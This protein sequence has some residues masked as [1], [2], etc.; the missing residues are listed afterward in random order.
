MRRYRIAEELGGE[1]AL[2]DL[3]ARALRFGIRLAADFVPNHLAIDS[4]WVV[5]HPERFLQRSESPFPGYS[6]EGPD[7][8]PDP[9][10]SLQVEDHYHDRT[11][12]AVVFQRVDRET[13]DE[14]FIYHGNDGTSMPWND[15]AQL[16]YLRPEDA[17]GGP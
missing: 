2:E 6:F 5:E 8:S 15:T 9:R 14:R 13:G 17:G 4:E 7:L 16:D 11:D 1:Q 10:V 3:K 12:A